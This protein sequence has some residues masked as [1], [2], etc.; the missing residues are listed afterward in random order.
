M[1]DFPKGGGGLKAPTHKGDNLIFGQNLPITAWK[2]RKLDREV[3]QKVYYVDLPFVL[4]E[5]LKWSQSL[6]L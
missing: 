1:Q 6:S 5:I 2:W 3:S 4:K